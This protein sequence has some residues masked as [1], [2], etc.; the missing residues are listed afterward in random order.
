MTLALFA[1]SPSRTGSQCRS[2][3]CGTLP[4]ITWDK[5]ADEREHHGCITQFGEAL[6]PG[7]RRAKLGKGHGPGN[8]T[9]NPRNR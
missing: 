3:E 8:C 5:A 7:E 6:Q 4:R 9:E 2:G 1:H